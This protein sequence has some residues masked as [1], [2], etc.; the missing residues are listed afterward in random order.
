MHGNKNRFW[1]R[2]EQTLPTQTPPVTSDIGNYPYA[3]VRNG[4]YAFLTQVFSTE[5]DSAIPKEDPKGA[6]RTFYGNTAAHT[7][8]NREGNYS[9]EKDVAYWTCCDTGLV[10]ED[11]RTRIKSVTATGTIASR[12]TDSIYFQAGSATLNSPFTVIDDFA[13][14]ALNQLNDGTVCDAKYKISLTSTDQEIRTPG[15]STAFNKCTYILE[16]DGKAPGFAV[17]ASGYK[18]W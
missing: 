17:T 5:N 12:L 3:C 9:P 1:P 10:F 16:A 18:G 13:M 2:F 8:Y 15:T 14:V 11:C 6:A 4:Q 7:G